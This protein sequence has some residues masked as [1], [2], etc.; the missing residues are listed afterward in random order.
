M[1][2]FPSHFLLVLL[3]RVFFSPPPPS[4]VPPPSP[5][6]LLPS[7]PLSQT[8]TGDQGASVGACVA[9]HGG[10]QLMKDNEDSEGDAP[11]PSTG[12]GRSPQGS[13]KRPQGWAD[14]SQQRSPPCFAD[15][16]LYFSW[17]RGIEGKVITFSRR[18]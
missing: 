9:R 12:L 17:G 14:H 18:I 8:A 6:S 2:P 16:L 15:S 10:G 3:S 11:Q 5:L 13:A 4:S 7:Q 1:L